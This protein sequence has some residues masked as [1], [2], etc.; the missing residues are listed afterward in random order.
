MSQ[1][2]ILSRKLRL[3]EWGNVHYSWLIQAPKKIDISGLSN[4][5]GDSYRYKNG[6]IGDVDTSSPPSLFQNI[7]T[8]LPFEQASA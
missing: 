2:D 3:N 7:D 4:G 5:S 6:L 8:N 1:G